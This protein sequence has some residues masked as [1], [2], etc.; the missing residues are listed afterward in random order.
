MA[1]EDVLFLQHQDTGVILG[2]V[3]WV[4]RIQ[5]C[6]SCGGDCNCGLDLI[7]GPGI[8]CAKGQLKKEEKKK[9]KTL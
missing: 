3:Q 5:C 7:P 1:K 6:Y 4:K 2:Q 9:K 8:S